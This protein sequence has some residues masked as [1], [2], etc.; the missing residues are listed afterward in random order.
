MRFADKTSKISR[1]HAELDRRTGT[2][3]AAGNKDFRKKLQNESKRG[4]TRDR[5]NKQA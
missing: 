4:R 2:R 1:G 5:T 3:S